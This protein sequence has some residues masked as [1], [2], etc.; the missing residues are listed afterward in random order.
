MSLLD[1]CKNR[2]NLT[3][4]TQKTGINLPDMTKT[5]TLPDISKNYYNSILKTLTTVPDICTKSAVTL[6][7]IPKPI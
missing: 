6:L 5:I 2:Y 1:I 4:Y 7:D 3:R